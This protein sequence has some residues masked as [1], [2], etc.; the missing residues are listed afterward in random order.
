MQVCFSPLRWAQLKLRIIV[1]LSANRNLDAYKQERR[2][3]FA[4]RACTVLENDF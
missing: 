2:S 3:Q 4:P 1:D